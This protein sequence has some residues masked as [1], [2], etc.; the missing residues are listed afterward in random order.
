VTRVCLQIREIDRIRPTC[1][2]ETGI[3]A[4]LKPAVSLDRPV[5]AHQ[6]KEVEIFDAFYDIA[7]GPGADSAKG[8]L[9][10]RIEQ[11]AWDRCDQNNRDGRC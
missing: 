9:A 4:L 7:L 10:R 6:S 5:L 1:D 3:N 8:F 2:D 11:L